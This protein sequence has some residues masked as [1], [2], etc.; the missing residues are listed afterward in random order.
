MSFV[1]CQRDNA[2][3][4]DDFGSMKLTVMF[5]FISRSSLLKLCSIFIIVVLF[6]RFRRECTS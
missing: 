1:N 2:A 6:Y 5:G 3:K 4:V